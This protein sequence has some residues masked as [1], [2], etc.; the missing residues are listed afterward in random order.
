VE[1]SRC[2]YVK[3]LLDGDE[4]HVFVNHWPSRRGGES[5]TAPWRAAGAK[6]CREVSDSI[7]QIN[8]NAK[9]FIMGDLNDNPT[10][11]SVKRVLNAKGKRVNVP[12][13]G[14]YNT[15][16]N[17]FN[18]GIGSNAYRDTWSL[19]DQII[20]SKALLDNTKAGYYY[21]KSY[22]YNKKF[23][24]QKRGH[25]KGYPFRTFSGDEFIGGY[26]D[27]FPVFVHLLKEK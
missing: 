27:H 19:F 3:G 22:V 7:M 9:I 17:Y 24:L 5:R 25:F 8:P 26:S 23:L 13:K 16:E 1:S 10:S 21:H 2:K 12:E 15:M 18:R 11:P 4:I 14:F 20:I 6:V